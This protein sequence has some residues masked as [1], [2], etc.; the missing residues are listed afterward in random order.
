MRTY[1]ENKAIRVKNDDGKIYKLKSI[2]TYN[3]YDWMHI[4][5]ENVEDEEDTE[6]VICYFMQ[7]S[8]KECLEWNE[9]T[10]VENP[11]GK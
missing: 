5:L 2:E 7:E 1:M 11:A 9:Y 4:N 6:Q 3:G 8:V 10:I